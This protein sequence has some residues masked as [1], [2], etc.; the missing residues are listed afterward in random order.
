M[1]KL[2][3]LIA[4]PFTPFDSDGE[5]ALEKIATLARL[6]DAND[7]TGAFICGSTGEGVSLTF[8]E[9][10]QVMERWGMVKGPRLKAIFMLGGTCL[11]EM[12]LLARHA[13]GHNMDGVS[14]LC[15]YY[16]KPGSV[17]QLVRFCKSVADTAPELPFYYYHIPALTGGHFMMAEFLALAESEIPNLAGIKFT[18]PNIM[19]FHACRMYKEG[20]YDILWGIDEALLSGLAAGAEGAVGSTYNYAAPLYNQII[21]AFQQGETKEAERLQQFAVKMVALLLKYGGTGAGKAFMKLIGL[22]CGWFRA[23]V[24]SPTDEEVLSLKIELE[25]IGFFDFCSQIK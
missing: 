12:Q 19:D 10:K 6:Y 21:R 4:A 23:P 5:L 3:G 1:E 18:A 24:Q 15:P 7:V 17:A 25:A 8:E 13:A 22:D 16:F 14:I 11:K 2:K 20:K 9:K